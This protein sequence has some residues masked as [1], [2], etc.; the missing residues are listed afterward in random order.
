MHEEK[1][2]Q[3]TTAGSRATTPYVSQDAEISWKTAESCTLHT[4]PDKA[5]P[6][7][8]IRKGP[9]MTNKQ[10]QDLEMQ[11]LADQNEMY[12]TVM[13]SHKEQVRISKSVPTFHIM[14]SV[15]E[16]HEMT[17]FISES[18]EIG[19]DIYEIWYLRGR[20]WGENTKSCWMNFIIGCI[21]PI[22]PYFTL[23]LNQSL[24]ISHRMAHHTET[25][26]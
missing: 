2:T 12:E 19:N 1:K 7:G 5:A 24:S 10:D 13:E 14:H 17:C 6:K 11:F 15:Y 18:T 3:A 20:E 25:G 4:A 23:I 16:E 22:N 9:L 8:D 26:A 21:G